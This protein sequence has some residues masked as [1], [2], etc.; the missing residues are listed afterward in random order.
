M[1]AVTKRRPGNGL[2]LDFDHTPA[3]QESATSSSSVSSSSSPQQSSS[4]TT[5]PTSSSQ[6]RAASLALAKLNWSLAAQMVNCSTSSHRLEGLSWLADGCR[7]QR[8][9]NNVPHRLRRQQRRLPFAAGQALV[10]GR[11]TCP[12][13]YGDYCRCRLLSHVAH[14]KHCIQMMQPAAGSRLVTASGSH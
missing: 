7:L 14:C 10:T 9:C 13:D 8:P 4:S 2:F 3:S 6:P 5:P 12:G 1:T 11:K